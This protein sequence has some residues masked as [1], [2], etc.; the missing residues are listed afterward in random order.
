MMANDGAVKERERD[1]IEG[2]RE[3]F[4]RRKTEAQS[5]KEK[6]REEGVAGRDREGEGKEGDLIS[7]QKRGRDAMK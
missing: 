6:E 3:E 7:T 2:K 5:E 4:Y 1:R